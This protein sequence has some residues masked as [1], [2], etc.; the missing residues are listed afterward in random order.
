MMQFTYKD[1]WNC[2]MFKHTTV[3]TLLNNFQTFLNIHCKEVK[4]KSNI[5]QQCCKETQFSIFM[6]SKDSAGDYVL[7][8]GLYVY[9]CPRC[10]G[11]KVKMNRV[12]LTQICKAVISWETKLVWKLSL[13]IRLNSTNLMEE[14][15]IKWQKQSKYVTIEFSNLF[16]SYL[17]TQV[18]NS[19]FL[20][21]IAEKP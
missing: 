20:H 15:Q 13:E 3:D 14:T 6:H 1:Y 10:Y 16:L 21:C 19:Q 8:A 2:Y 7:L 4:C 12:T 11:R 9:F 18:R 17:H 5:Q